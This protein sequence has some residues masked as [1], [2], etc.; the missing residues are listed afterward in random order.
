MSTRHVS[1]SQFE[2][3]DASRERIWSLKECLFVVVVTAKSYCAQQYINLY[4]LG[5]IYKPYFVDATWVV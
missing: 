1:F 2:P 5:I 4:A 3:F